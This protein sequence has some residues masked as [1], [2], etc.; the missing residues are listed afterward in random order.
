MPGFDMAVG[1]HN[2]RSRNDVPH[3]ALRGFLQVVLSAR[4]GRNLPE[5]RQQSVDRFMAN[6]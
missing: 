6:A 4:V 1:C 3:T 5:S 2:R